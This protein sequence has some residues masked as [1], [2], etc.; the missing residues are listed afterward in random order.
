MKKLVAL[1]LTFVIA[2]LPMVACNTGERAETTAS[3]APTAEPEPVTLTLEGSGT[4]EA[5]YLIAT[6]EDLYQ[7]A[8]AL[9]KKNVHEDKQALDYRDYQR[10]HYRLTADL[11]LNDVSD[12]DNWEINPP[13]NRWVPM[14][15]LRGSFD[16]DGHTITGLY[17]RST[18]E[19]SEETY[20]RFGLFSTVIGSVCN[21]R[22]EKAFVDGR[23]G[24]SSY[25]VGLLAGDVGAKGSLRNCHGKGVVFGQDSGGAISRC[26]GLVGSNSG[27]I[28]DC[29]FKGKVAGGNSV[30]IGG[31]GGYSSGTISNCKVSAQV[32]GECASGNGS[33]VGGIVGGLSAFGKQDAVVENCTF[34]G[35]VTSNWYAGGI[36]ALLSGGKEVQAIVRN[37]TNLGS[38]TGQ[39]DA[40]GIA[41]ATL[42]SGIRLENSLNRGKVLSLDT[43]VYASGGIL[44]YANVSVTIGNCTNEG[45]ISAYVPGGIL[46]RTMPGNKAVIRLENC[47]NRGVMQGEG[48]NAG[49]ILCSIMSFGENW[50]IVL[51]H[52]INEGT[53]MATPNGGGIVG[54]AFGLEEEPNTLTISNCTNKGTLYSDGSNCFLGGILGINS[55][56]NSQVT[57]D[58][59]R[60]E[61][62]LVF[63]WE[64]V[65]DAQT[66]SGTMF[67]L[68]RIGGGM[69]GYAGNYPSLTVRIQERRVKNVEVNNAF[70]QITNCAFTGHFSHKELRYA[71]DVTEELLDKWKASGYNTENFYIALEGGVLGFMADDKAFSVQTANCTYPHVERAIDDCLRFPDRVETKSEIG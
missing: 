29:T 12:F 33:D 43:S 64:P 51:D 4:E 6:V 39:A 63:T 14:G 20:G 55:L 71:E 11:V 7:V 44:G 59:C 23:Q 56:K 2:L 5:P 32:T 40:G 18:E 42:S 27:L 19:L 69:V 61:G 24:T 13:E 26:G 54:L 28:S 36:A 49:G 62:D 25:S 1:L 48:F 53:I 47:T 15:E 8:A 60:S 52:C 9:S 68:S 65:L 35:E 67:T 46:G 58:N 37:C 45:D 22:L 34:E 17:C 30:Y 66:L 70:M 41:G 50:E 10:S 38:V 31:L 21:L 16:G 3:P 57:L